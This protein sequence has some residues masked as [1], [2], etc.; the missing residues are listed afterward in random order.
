[1]L[2]RLPHCSTQGCIKALSQ[3]C[4]CILI[5]EYRTT[6]RCCFCASDSEE[7]FVDTDKSRRT[8]TC[9]NP[10]CAMY[11]VPACRDRNSA[12]N[13]GRAFFQWACDHTRPAYLDSTSAWRWGVGCDPEG[14][15]TLSKMPRTEEDMQR[16]LAEWDAAKVRQEEA[17]SKKKRKKKKKE[18][19]TKT[20]VEAT[21]LDAE[22][23]RSG[24]AAAGGQADCGAARPWSAV[25]NLPLPGRRH[26]ARLEATHPST[27]GAWAQTRKRPAEWTAV[28][29]ESKGG[30]DSDSDSDVAID[31]QVGTWSRPLSLI[32][33]V[34]VLGAPS[35]PAGLDHWHQPE[36]WQ[37]GRVDHFRPSPGPASGGGAGA[38]TVGGGLPRA[39]SY[40]PFL[41]ALVQQA[42]TLKTQQVSDHASAGPT[43]S[44]A[45]VDASGSA[46]ASA[47]VMVPAAVL[48]RQ[49]NPTSAVH[50]E[51]LPNTRDPV[52][53]SR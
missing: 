27:G 47:P 30:D 9:V 24:R 39:V 52:L 48:R 19:K 14:W 36:H 13:I 8:V 50:S 23:A 26:G 53:S 28:E 38:S 3:Y 15:T 12:Y 6:K 44:D 42:A 25:G 18:K 7:H 2:V 45:T 20:T 32:G 43:G 46:I 37:L 22:A 17:A 51:R 29:D 21:G 1:M 11:G 5:N 35:R 10:D 49:P 16:T 34:P 31:I 33:E 4:R 40:N 41:A